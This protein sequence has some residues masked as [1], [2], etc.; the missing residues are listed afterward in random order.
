METPPIACS[1]SGADLRVRS[2]EWDGLL[3]R[4]LISA[5]AIPAGVRLNVEPGAAAELARLIDLER[6]CG[7]WMRFDFED[8]ETVAIT[9]EGEGPEVLRA[10]FLERHPA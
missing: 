2:A 4:S 8:L 9:A 5:L 10:M 3:S 7:A 1:L 6:A